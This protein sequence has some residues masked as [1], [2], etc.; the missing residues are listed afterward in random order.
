M[1]IHQP[2]NKRKF[3]PKASGLPFNELLRLMSPRPGSDAAVE[4]RALPH[5][6]G[7][8]I[9]EAFVKANVRFYKDLG[10]SNKK[11]T[12]QKSSDTVRV[13]LSHC[14][15]WRMAGPFRTLESASGSPVEVVST[16]E[17]LGFQCWEWAK[18]RGVP[19]VWARDTA[20]LA[21]D[22]EDAVHAKTLAMRYPF[23]GIYDLP[24]EVERMPIVEES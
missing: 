24:E 21:R 1:R 20:D 10:E 6:F 23:Y 7:A 17:I 18:R 8:A 15:L 3:R 22:D 5:E 14:T 16:G 13:Q 19:P 4:S 11:S 9:G 12:S 2:Q